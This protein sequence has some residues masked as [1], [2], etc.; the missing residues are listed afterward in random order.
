MTCL[1]S[2]PSFLGQCFDCATLRIMARQRA[3]LAAAIAADHSA[4]AR[5]AH[6]A[7]DGW[8]DLSFYVVGSPP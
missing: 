5:A 2:R 7:D 3:E 1:H 6:K 4:K 8:R